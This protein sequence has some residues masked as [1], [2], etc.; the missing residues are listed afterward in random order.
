MPLAPAAEAS[1]SASPSASGAKSSA[2]LPPPRKSSRKRL[3]TRSLKVRRA[4]SGLGAGPRGPGLRALAA[5]GLDELHPQ[6]DQL[7]LHP[8]SVLDGPTQPGHQLPGHVEAALAALLPEREEKSRML[9]PAGTGGAP[10][11]DAR[12]AHLGEGAF[13][14]RPAPREVR[15]KLPT[16]LR[17]HGL[18]LLHDGMYT[19]SNTYSQAEKQKIRKIHSVPDPFPFLPSPKPAA[20]HGVP[21]WDRQERPGQPASARKGPW[22]GPNWP[23]GRPPYPAAGD[24]AG[25]PQRPRRLSGP[26]ELVR[27]AHGESGREAPL[28]GYRHLQPML[29][30]RVPPNSLAYDSAPRRTCAAARR[31]IASTSLPAASGRR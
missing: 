27:S 9:L 30:G 21:A 15:E 26:V 11:P 7:G 2:G 28:R 1:S 12:L 22:T 4:P 20:F 13:G 31:K 25:L 8:A 10:R 6:A 18:G 17:V 19:T 3:A 29:A 14:Q 5:M 23:I 16:V 24:E